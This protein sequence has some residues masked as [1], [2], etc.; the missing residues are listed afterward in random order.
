MQVIARDVTVAMTVKDQKMDLVG[1]QIVKDDVLV[2]LQVFRYNC[3]S[4]N[5]H[6]VDDMLSSNEIGYDA[7]SISS[8]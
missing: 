1:I 2:M 7:I 8:Q 5:G 3:L 6:A 4:C